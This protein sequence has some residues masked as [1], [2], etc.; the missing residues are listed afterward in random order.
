MLKLGKKINYLAIFW[1][2]FYFL[3]FV[4]LFR[5][6]FSYL[7]PDLGWHLK[8]G[9]EIAMTGGVPHVNV[10]N[11]TYTGNWV[12]HEWLINYISFEIYNYFGYL[13][14]SIFFTLIIVLSLILLKT[15]VKRFLPK[16]PDWLV[17]SLQLFGLLGCMSSFGIRMQEWG[18]LFLL[19]ELWIIAEF[20]ETKKTKV[21][22]WLLPLFYLWS[23]MHGSFLV[24]LCLLFAWP[25]VKLIERKVL[26]TKLK[27]Y[28]IETNVVKISELKVFILFF[29]GSIA[30]TFFTPYSTEL[31]SF[32][33]GYTDSFYQSAIQEWRPEYIFPFNY[34]QLGYLALIT[35]LIALY[36]YE[37]TRK[38]ELKVEIWQ[39]CLSGF[40]IILGFQARRHF[41]L[42]FISTFLFLAQLIYLIFDLENF[43]S[44][45]LRKELRWLLLVCLGLAILGQVNLLKI[46]FDPF[47]SYC[48]D[49]PCGAVGFL[50]NNNQYENLN[51]FND[52]NW[53]GYLI[54]T[55][56]EKK[57]CIDGRLPQEKYAG[58]TFLEEYS[59]FLKP[60]TNIAKKLE[61]YN[62][63]L[64]LI[65]ST[66]YKLVV[67]N[68][69]KILFMIR[70]NDLSQPNYLRRYLDNSKNWQRIYTD[71]EASIYI[72]IN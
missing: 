23:N 17:A 21:L 64:V 55:Y 70:D 24:G 52:Y 6:S 42:M 19:L 53:G 68:W 72:K 35:S 1:I 63:K 29:L 2:L 12:D 48:S 43:K 7:D 32:L 49:Y 13:G 26:S 3:I 38:R 10:Y 11:Y 71:A 41:P 28:F 54:W 59:D 46:K 33:G 61:Q 16:I 56:P 40:F 34:W 66:D 69:E 44:F 62:I 60:E 15:F 30:L 51:I 14:L 67:K 20:N 31:Y 45:K 39:I 37:L 57:L 50:K 47:N 27:K 22:I 9:Q 18:F 5:N 25:V 36:I 4:L 58:H 65:R 8:V